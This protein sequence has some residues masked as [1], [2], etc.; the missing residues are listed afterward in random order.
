MPRLVWAKA[1]SWASA[2]GVGEEEGEEGGAG[3]EV[4]AAVVFPV[5]SV[6]GGGEHVE[7]GEE[8]VGVADAFGGVFG[9]S[10]GG[11]GADRFG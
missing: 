9:E 3:G 8:G 11:D 10:C 1:C 5:G 7:L 4:C 6:G 2:F